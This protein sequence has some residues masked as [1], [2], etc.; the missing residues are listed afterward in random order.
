MIS[1]FKP[2][3]RRAIYFLGSLWALAIVFLIA[4]ALVPL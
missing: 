1:R 4:R 2:P 3:Q